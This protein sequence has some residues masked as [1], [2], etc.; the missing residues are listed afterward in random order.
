MGRLVYSLFFQGVGRTRRSSYFNTL[1]YVQIFTFQLSIPCL[2]W[3]DANLC[4]FHCVQ[5]S[6]NGSEMPQLLALALHNNVHSGTVQGL[7]PLL[8][9]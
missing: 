8:G 9:E 6:V 1:P 3:E 4:H 7:M 2:G 5:F